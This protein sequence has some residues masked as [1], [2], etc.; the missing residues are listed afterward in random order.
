MSD[1]EKKK[2]GLNDTFALTISL[3]IFVSLI[4]VFVLSRV[5][6]T[7][8]PEITLPE[9]AVSTGSAELPGDEAYNSSEQLKD[10]V[11]DETNVA[12]IIATLSRPSEY[13]VK[14]SATLYYSEHSVTSELTHYVSHGVSRTDSDDGM[15]PYSVIVSGRRIYT[16]APGSDEFVVSTPSETSGDDFTRA[17]TYESLTALPASAI[18]DASLLGEYIYVQ[19]RDEALGYDIY[20]SISLQYGLLTNFTVM[21]NNATVYNCSSAGITVGSVPDGTFTLPNGEVVG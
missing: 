11:I 8:T 18:I 20:W 10:V 15:N 2:R 7:R 4:A 9:Q 5:N 19:T 1:K 16:F 13:T 21:K 6:T 12:R 17:P 14:M 3:L